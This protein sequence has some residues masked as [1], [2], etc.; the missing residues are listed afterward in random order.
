MR[1]LVRLIGLS[2][3]LCHADNV[4]W[5]DLLDAWAKRPGKKGSAGDDRAPAWR[6]MGSLMHKVVHAHAMSRH[7]QADACHTGRHRPLPA[8]G[9]ALAGGPCYRD[10]GVS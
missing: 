6:W 9:L 2:P 3:L 10:G 5:G 1:F 4:A 7:L 8:T